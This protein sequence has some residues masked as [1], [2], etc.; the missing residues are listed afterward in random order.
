MTEDQAAGLIVDSRAWYTDGI[1][2]RLQTSDVV[3]EQRRATPEESEV[4]DRVARVL[5]RKNS[6]SDI[7]RLGR[8]VGVA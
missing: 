1:G 2:W 3:W 8:S 6:D 4:F 7:S 5:G